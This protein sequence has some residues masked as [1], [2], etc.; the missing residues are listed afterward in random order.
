MDD[1]SVDKDGKR[2]IEEKFGICDTWLLASPN[3]A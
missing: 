1:V 3:L 2:D